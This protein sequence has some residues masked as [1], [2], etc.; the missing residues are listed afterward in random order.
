MCPPAFVTITG[1][2]IP[3]VLSTSQPT[4][5]SFWINLLSVIFAIH[6]AINCQ[7]SISPGYLPLMVPM[8]I[9]Y[10]SGTR[11]S[12]GIIHESDG[13]LQS[14]N[15]L[16]YASRFSV[17]FLCTLLS[18]VPT[19]D[20]YPYLHQVRNA[21][22]YSE[23]VRDRIH[24]APGIFTSPFG[25]F[26]PFLSSILYICYQSDWKAGQIAQIIL[27]SFAKTSKLFL[28]RNLGMHKNEYAAM[29]TSICSLVLVC[30]GCDCCDGL[31]HRINLLGKIF[32][33]SQRNQYGI[34]QNLLASSF[35]AKLGYLPTMTATME[36]TM[37]D[38]MKNTMI[39]RMMSMGI[40]M[41]MT[42]HK[43]RVMI[44]MD[45]MMETTMGHIP[46]GLYLQIYSLL[47]NG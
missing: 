8:A 16:G 15:P 45:T 38:M 19:T 10:P 40:R 46:K 43:L 6:K 3:A 18:T 11:Q 1:S 35:I 41:M 23:Q 13:R 25:L 30:S 32:H 20:L 7:P 33:S 34:K 9:I 26:L 44:Q 4:K 17:Y 47:A 12:H 28:F 39:V 2:S 31:T 42:S 22:K 37:M 27:Q 21:E 14:Q 5:A 24:G 36:V 29:N